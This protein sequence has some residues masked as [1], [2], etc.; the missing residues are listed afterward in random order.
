MSTVVGIVLYNYEAV[1]MTE[2]TPMCPTL[3]L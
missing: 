1:F 3:H 2:M